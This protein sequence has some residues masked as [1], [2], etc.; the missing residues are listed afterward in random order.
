MSVSKRT[1]VL[2]GSDSCSFL[3][4][5]SEMLRIFE[6][7]PVGHFGNRE[8]R[9]KFILGAGYDKA[10]DVCSCTFAGGLADKVAEIIGRHMERVSTETHRRNAILLLAPVGEIVAQECVETRKYIVVGNTSREKL[11]M[12][13]ALTETQL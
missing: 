6:S 10:A 4:H 11:S 12:V 5:P 13:E 2:L 3:K 8:S 7:E 9:S 1:E